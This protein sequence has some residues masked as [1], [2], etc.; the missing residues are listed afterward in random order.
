MINFIICDDNEIIRKNLEETINK[1]MMKNN[2]EYKIYSFSDYNKKFYN[3]MEKPLLNKIYILDIETPSESGI[4]IA[5][6]IRV[7][8]IESIIIFLTSHYELGSVLLEDEIMFL[9]FISKFNNSDERMI[10]AI[11]KAIQMLG[12]KQ[13]IRFENHGVL[14]TIPINDILYIT[15][16]SVSRKSVVKTEYTEFYIAKSLTEMSDL[17]D[18]RFI[19]THKSCLANKDRINVMDKKKNTII[20]DNGICINLLSDKYKEGTGIV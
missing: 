5:R 6:R 16:D 15:Y 1:I 20:F 2:F 10:S 18:N 8:D 4:N 12:Q 19:R 7:K 13:A 11:N 3:V 14:Y 17:V 9:T